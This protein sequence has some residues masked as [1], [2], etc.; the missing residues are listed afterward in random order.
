MTAWR[1]IYQELGLLDRFNEKKGHVRLE[2]YVWKDHNLPTS[3]GIDRLVKTVSKRE[4]ILLRIDRCR[5]KRIV[6]RQ[7]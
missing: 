2:C 6:L 7:V 4:G 1:L 3:S 5:A